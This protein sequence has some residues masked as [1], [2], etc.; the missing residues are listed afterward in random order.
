M[1][2][3]PGFSLRLLLLTALMICMTSE[4]RAG[5]CR[6]SMDA[7]LALD[8]EAFDQEEGGWRA[9][10]RRGRGDVADVIRAYR[11]AHEKSLLEWQRDLLLWH[12][13]QLRALHGDYPTA[14]R[15]MR[16]SSGAPFEAHNLYVAATI[17]FLEGDL[18]A[19][20]AARAKLAALPEP[21]EYA[22][23]AKQ[24]RARTDTEMGWPP[25]LNVVDGLVRCFG[26]PY[27]Q[28]YSCGTDANR[29]R[30]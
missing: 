2:I 21:P 20:K 27:R 10:E 25:N 4:S 7:L 23:A 16:D 12:E 8:F 17:A 18:A 22:D 6:G 24:F 13:A 11:L 19:L 9:A 15:L 14:V 5:E 29:P 3:G 30:E 1:R 26:Q 28:A